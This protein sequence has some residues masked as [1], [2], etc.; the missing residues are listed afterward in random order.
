MTRLDLPLCLFD[1][2]FPAGTDLDIIFSPLHRTL[3]SESFIASRVFQESM[4][5]LA[6]EVTSLRDGRRRRRW[7]GKGREGTAERRPSNCHY[8]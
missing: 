7:K 8:G 3:E 2:E 6:D 5:G 1:E 4:V